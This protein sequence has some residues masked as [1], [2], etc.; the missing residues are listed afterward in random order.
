[1]GNIY[2]IQHAETPR[3]AIVARPRGDERLY[4]ELLAL[5]A[6]GID[7]LVSL[8][9]PDEA[10][11]LG[12]AEEGEL[13]QRAGLEFVWYPITDR[14]T[15]AD[16]Q[17]FCELIAYLTE[18]IRAGRNVGAHCQGCIGRSTVTTASV[19]IE[20]GWNAKDAI[21]LIEEARHFPVPDTAEQL[22]WI[23]DFKPC[24]QS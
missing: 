5:K 18:A 12:L 1:M 2:W 14:G 22:R 7:I 15:P 10:V 6:S 13:A 9:E 11:Y 23:L 19:M 16:T 8:L 21:R 17:H 20:S 4:D 3:L 24:S